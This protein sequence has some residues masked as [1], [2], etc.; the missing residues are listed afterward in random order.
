MT[1]S[2]NLYVI[3]NRKFPSATYGTDDYLTNWPMLYILENGDKV[4]IGE[5]TNVAERMKQHYNNQVK[6]S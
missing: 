4:Y 5:S 1:T 2:E 6:V 3:T